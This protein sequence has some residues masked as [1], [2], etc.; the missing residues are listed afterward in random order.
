[1]WRPDPSKDL[2]NTGAPAVRPHRR[3]LFWG[4][5]NPRNQFSKFPL[6]PS[7]GRPMAEQ[8]VPENGAK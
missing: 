2:T 1:M 3:R 5:T 6:F 8:I 4:G 7:R